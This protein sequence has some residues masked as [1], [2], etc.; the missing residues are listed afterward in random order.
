MHV[1]CTCDLLTSM[2]LDIAT[3]VSDATT[4]SGMAEA[5]AL[6]PTAMIVAE[7]QPRNSRT[8]RKDEA[9]WKSLSSE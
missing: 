3:T 9:G 1:G 2:R 4:I 7:E 6:W 8:R 5:G